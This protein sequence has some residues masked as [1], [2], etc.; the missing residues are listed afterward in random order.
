MFFFYASLIIAIACS[1]ITERT[2]VG[3]NDVH[4]SIKLGTFLLFLAMWFTPATLS[5]IRRRMWFNDAFYNFCADFGYI[6]FG[7]AF[8]LFV[9][10]F[11]RDGLWFSA[12]YLSGRKA[13]LDP[14]NI[15]LL[16]KMN[17]ATVALAV[18]I[19]AYGF[20]QAVKLPRVKHLTLYS[21]K[22]NNEIKVLQINDLHLHRNKP[23]KDFA[24]I[25]NL[26]NSLNPDIIAMPGDIID[27]SVGQLVPHLEALSNLRAKYGVFVSPGN[28]EYYNGLIPSVWQMEQIGFR[29]LSENGYR[30]D[31]LNL[32]IAGIPDNPMLRKMKEYPNL[33]D[34]SLPYDYKILLA[35][36][37]TLSKEY[38][39]LGFDLQLSAH[40][41]GG[42]IF[43]FHIMVK[44]VNHYL[45][46]EYKIGKGT[47][48]ISNGAGY[49]GPP[50]RLLAPSDITLITIKPME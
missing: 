47:L 26:A 13:V 32:Y 6:C 27:D 50:M 7:F 42:Q 39:A 4:W 41:H 29:V 40:T 21:S 38:M 5:V 24:A 11:V 18:I 9:L 44:L 10:I 23:V 37:P 15:G 33:F 2:L 45:S 1:I 20:Y 25:A 46:G 30:I 28:H 35:H 22:I 16:T 14:F 43:P 36:N 31:D 48:Y 8:I 49:W 12:Y 17:I 19:S 3:Y 34:G